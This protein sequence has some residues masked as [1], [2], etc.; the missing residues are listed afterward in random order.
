MAVPPRTLEG[1]YCLHDLRRLD[2]GRWRNAPPAEREQAVAELVD[3]LKAC[4][5]VADAPEGSSAFA[6]VPGHKGDLLFMHLRPELE[7]LVRLEHRFN[8]LAVVAYMERTTSFVSVTELSQYVAGERATATEPEA[9]SPEQE[10]FVQRRLKPELPRTRYMSFYPMDKRRG[11]QVNWYTLPLEERARMMRSH[12]RIGAGYKGQVQQLVTGS[13]GLDDW[14][15]GVTL[16]AD[17]ALPLKKIVQEMRFDEAS[18]LYGLF[19]PFYVGV[20][21][22]PGQVGAYLQGQWPGRAGGA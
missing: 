3:F 10:A 2:W 21:M 1:W 11:E 5:E 9:R 4:R 8:Q 20:Q 12:G 17:D 15:W 19:G 7:D 18:S 14:E 13:V 16:F 6:A 22:E